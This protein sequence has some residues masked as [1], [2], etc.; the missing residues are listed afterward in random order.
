[1]NWGHRVPF[2]EEPGEGAT[3][4]QLR[5]MVAQLRR[6]KNRLEEHVSFLEAEVAHLTQQVESRKGWRLW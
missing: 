3:E 2:E 6:E 1:M 4:R 5:Q